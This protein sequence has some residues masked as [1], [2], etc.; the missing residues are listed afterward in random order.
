[1]TFYC[2]EC[3]AQTSPAAFVG[4]RSDALLLRWWVD[5]CHTKVRSVLSSLHHSP[6]C[7]SHLL[8]PLITCSVIATDHMLYYRENW[9]KTVCSL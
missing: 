7:R 3:T 4:L 9:E 5:G 8:T 6:A 2:D 1:M